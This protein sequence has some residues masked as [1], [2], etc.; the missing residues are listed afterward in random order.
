VGKRMLLEPLAAWAP[1]G[2]GTSSSPAQISGQL[3]NA[4]IGTDQVPMDTVQQFDDENYY[5]AFTHQG[6]FGTLWLEIPGP[7]PFVLTAVSWVH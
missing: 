1:P 4:W 2:G 3:W 7:E 5:L 6:K